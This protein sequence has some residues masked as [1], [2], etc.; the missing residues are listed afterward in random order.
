MVGSLRPG[1]HREAGDQLTFEKVQ[2]C[3]LKELDLNF[4]CV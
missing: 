3:V 4:M 1:N 2:E